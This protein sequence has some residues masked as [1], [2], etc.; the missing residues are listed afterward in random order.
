MCAFMFME[1]KGKIILEFS[2][3]APLSGALCS[4]LIASNCFEVYFLF[5]FL[6]D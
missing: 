2:G 5:K 3:N 1:K 6:S 4:L